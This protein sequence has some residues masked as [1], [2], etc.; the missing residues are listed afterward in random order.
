MNSLS[1]IPKIGPKTIEK[2]NR[3]Q[4]FSPLDILYHFPAR[5]VDFS[6]IQKISELSV[7]SAATIFGTLQKFNNIFTRSHKNIQIATVFDNS[8]SINLIWFNQP[9]LSKNF[10]VGQTYS[11]AGTVTL[12]Q[13]KKTIIGAMSGS[14]N[15]GQI[16]A[17]YEETRGLKSSFFRQIIST[18]NLPVVETLPVP[19]LKKY[20]LLNLSTALT[21]IHHPTNSQMLAKASYRLGLDEILS[22]QSVSFLNKQQL[23]SQKVKQVFVDSP[24]I[25]KLIKK[26]PF[27]LTRSQVDA[28]QEIK[29]DLLG[30]KPSN[31]L[32]QGD[33]GSGKTIVALLACYLAYQN[34]STSLLIA[35]TE[36]LAKQ[37]LATFQKILKTKIYF[38]SGKHKPKK[39]PKGSIIIATHAAIYQKKWF[40]ANIGLLIIDEQHKFGVKQRSFL[41]DSISPPH[42]ITMTATPIPRTVSLTIMG[43][44]D[45]STLDSVPQN[46]LPVKTFV[47]PENKYTDCYR[48]LATHI[49]KTREQAFIVCPFIEPSETMATVKDATSLFKHLQQE[50]FTSLKLALIH[51]KMKESE[52]QKVLAG[53]A[54]NKI[55]ILIS[56]PII[57]VGIDFPNATTIIIQSADRFGL[58][59]LHQLRGRVGRSSLQ[60][61]CYLFSES[62]S[63][64]AK[65]RLN[66][67]K[68]NHNGQQ[69]AEYDLKNRG[70]G[71]AFSIIQHGFPSLKI[72]NYNDYELINTGQKIIK[73]LVAL[74]FDLNKLIKGNYL[75]IST[76]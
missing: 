23:S 2:L 5:Y 60:S 30:T 69:I 48:W 14:K 57:E 32:L 50:V 18:L 35:P 1:S 31:R 53:F 9:Y 38:L 16:I 7:N 55:D 74:K 68:N 59:Q 75:P 49:L 36:I 64:V 37:H 47:V 63:D 44:L 27:V 10:I 15:T 66:I 20:N 76:N 54:S 21:Q 52:R 28:W 26:L 3:L 70:P 56:T 46:R 45:L 58:A 51:G 72:A 6:H 19:I 22:L 43:N 33:V 12:Y 42:C 11:F 73:D 8:D 13:N 71:D 41:F 61:Y 25:A 40:S 65:N 34:K 29:S 67:L 62:T 39:I 4:I 24:K 17:V